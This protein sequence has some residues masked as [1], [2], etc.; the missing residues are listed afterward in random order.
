MV[1]T[2]SLVACEKATE[3]EP[4]YGAFDGKLPIP[5]DG[6]SKTIGLFMV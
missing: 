5:L 3:A 2:T 4:T 1:S 6:D